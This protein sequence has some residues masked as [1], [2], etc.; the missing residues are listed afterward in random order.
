LLGVLDDEG[1]RELH[2]R[3][4]GSLIEHHPDSGQTLIAD[5]EFLKLHKV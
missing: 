3:V 2:E 5:A 1:R 4:I